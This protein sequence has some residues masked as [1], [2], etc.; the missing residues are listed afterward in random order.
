MKVKAATLSARSA[1]LFTF[2][3]FIAGCEG[4]VECTGTFQQVEGL[5]RSAIVRALNEE[6]KD[7]DLRRNFSPWYS[8]MI[9]TLTRSENDPSLL[10]PYQPYDS[11][12][13][14]RTGFDDQGYFRDEPDE[15]YRLAQKQVDSLSLLLHDPRP[16][17]WAEC[18]TLVETHVIHYYCGGRSVARVRVGCDFRQIVCEPWN[19]LVRM[20]GLYGPGGEMLQRI[21]VK[22]EA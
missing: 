21:L 15:T 2:F 11:V 7:D 9:D 6:L 1:W 16:Y 4:E 5:D 20:G 18:G 19:R 22:R 14:T 3:A 12:M 8:W 13:V 17:H 10:F